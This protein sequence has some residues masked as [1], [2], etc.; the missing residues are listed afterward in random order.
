MTGNFITYLK[1]FF[2]E[3][4]Q[5]CS[6]NAQDSAYNLTASEDTIKIAQEA[7]KNAQ[8][9]VDSDGK[10]AVER[11]QEKSIQQSQQITAIS[12][13]SRKA[14][15]LADEHE[16]EA[17]KL[18][19]IGA[20]ARNTSLEAY[21]IAWNSIQQQR[22]AN[23][24]SRSLSQS[25]QQLE[26]EVKVTELKARG[27]LDVAKEAHNNALNLFKDA[28]SLTLPEIDFN[29]IKDQ[30]KV[31]KAEAET[32]KENV[33]K[34]LKEREQLLADAHIE[35]KRAQ[36]LISN[37]QQQQQTAEELLADLD[38]AKAS[39]DKAL[40]QSNDTYE[41]AKRIYDTL[42]GNQIWF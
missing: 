29:T 4:V 39:A 13:L 11:A 14:R 27:A 42:Q 41:E 24:E 7:L 19:K 1:F 23:D 38:N 25:V 21:D 3:S 22:S 26:D 31:A 10:D 28:Y 15:V 18:E 35:A 8:R 5:Q 30:A 12:E 32:L 9:Y 17:L 33:D 40:K 6:K 37:T 36:Q 16:E 34:L 2:R 20:S